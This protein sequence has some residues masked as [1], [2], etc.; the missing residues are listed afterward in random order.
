MYVV[1]VNECPSNDAVNPSDPVQKSMKLH[2]SAFFLNQMH[3]SCFMSNIQW[4]ACM[5]VCVHPKLLTTSGGTW[6]DANPI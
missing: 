4:Y 5:C 3:A 1:S 6:H 2:N